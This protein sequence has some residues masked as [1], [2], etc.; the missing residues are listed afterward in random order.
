MILAELLGPIRFRQQV[1]I[2]ATDVD[3][4]ALTEARH[5]NYSSQDLQTIP[6][7]LRDK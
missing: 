2:Y 6:P 1:K 3:E 4:E 5:A 7:A